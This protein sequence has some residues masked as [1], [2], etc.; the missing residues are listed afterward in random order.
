MVFETRECSSSSNA[1]I[2]N[3]LVSVF[4]VCLVTDHEFSHNIVNVAVD[5][6]TTLTVI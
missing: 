1:N 2:F 4:H 5:P 6:H 3:K